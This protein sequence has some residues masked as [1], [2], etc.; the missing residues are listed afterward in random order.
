VRCPQLRIRFEIAHS[1]R[2]LSSAFSPTIPKQAISISAFIQP[3]SLIDFLSRQ[4]GEFCF[5]YPGLMFDVVSKLR[6]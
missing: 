6:R 3:I 5:Y 2:D 1:P 4:D